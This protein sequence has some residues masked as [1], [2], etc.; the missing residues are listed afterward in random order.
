MAAKE[1]IIHN[2]DTI[3][4]IAISEKRS[5]MSLASLIEY[6]SSFFFY[7]KPRVFDRARLCRSPSCAVLVYIFHV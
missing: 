5:K 7:M 2:N 6:F 3:L 4:Y 1:R